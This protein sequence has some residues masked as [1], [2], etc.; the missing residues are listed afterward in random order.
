MPTARVNGQTIAYEDTGGDLPAI[1]F[2]HGLMMDRSMFAPQV[3]ALRDRWRC[4]AWDERGHGGTAGDALA[5]FTY[6]DSADDLAALLAHLDIE[7]AVLAGMSQGGFLSLRCA[8]THPAIV[9]ALVLIDTQAGV[10]DASRL[11]LYHQLVERWIEHDLPDDVA[12]FVEATILGDG[13]SGAPA[14]RAKWKRMAPADLL[15]CM[16]ALGGRDDITGRLG[17]IKAPALVIHGEADAAI[18]LD[19]AQALTHGLADARLVV[20]KGAGHA[21]NLTH[22]DPVNAAIEQFL[23]RLGQ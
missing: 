19:L 22:P 11:P 6:Y 23:R 14:W 17:E 8:L 4:I 9:R 13:W 2:S 15:A 20:V 1:V 21:A 10:E 3:E 18:S 7:R 16:A 5:P 12:D